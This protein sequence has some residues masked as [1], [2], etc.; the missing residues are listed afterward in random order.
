[1]LAA[2]FAGFWYVLPLVRRARD[3][4]RS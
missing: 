3:Q 2:A 4:A 1:V